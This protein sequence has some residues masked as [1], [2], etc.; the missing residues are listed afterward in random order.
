MR[1]GSV[2]SRWG[3]CGIFTLGWRLLLSVDWLMVSVYESKCR[4]KYT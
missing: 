1:S 4:G 3:G 2:R